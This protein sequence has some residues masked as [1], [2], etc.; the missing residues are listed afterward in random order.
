[1][2]GDKSPYVLVSVF[3]EDAKPED[4]ASALTKDYSGLMK[5]I[6]KKKGL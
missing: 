1:M 4:V 2:T 5:A 3:K 6:N